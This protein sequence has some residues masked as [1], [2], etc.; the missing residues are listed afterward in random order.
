MVAGG[1]GAVAVLPLPFG[2]LGH[3][4]VGDCS[5]QALR[6]LVQGGF[7]LLVYFKQL[8]FYRRGGIRS[9]P[10]PALVP[11]DAALPAASAKHR[12]AFSSLHSHLI[13][14]SARLLQGAEILPSQSYVWMSSESWQLQSE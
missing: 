8:G 2:I 12:A 11:A 10:R 9:M 13:H 4:F 5:V 3:V 1:R 14:S 6:L 7:C